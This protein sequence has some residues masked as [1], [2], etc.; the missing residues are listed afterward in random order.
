MRGKSLIILAIVAVVLIAAALWSREKP[1]TATSEEELL[2][3]DLMANINAVKTINFKSAG[4]TF[5][6]QKSEDG[7]ELDQKDGYAAD[8]EKVRAMLLGMARTKRLEA[9]TKNPDLYGKLQLEDVDNEGAQ[10]VLISLVDDKNKLLADVVFGK[11][12]SAKAG[13]A[14]REYYVRVGDDPQSWLVQSDFE[15]VKD[16]SQWLLQEVLAIDES[17]IRSAEVNHED[18][19]TIEVQRDSSGETN[20][21]LVDI[22]EGRKVKYEFS[23]NDVANSFANLKLQD[24]SKVDE[25]D[26]SDAKRAVVQSFDGLM[27]TLET[28]QKD[29]VTYARLNAEFSSESVEKNDS[30]ENAK[31]ETESADQSTNTINTI[32]EVKQEVE[33]L[34]ARWSGWAYQLPDFELNNIFKPMDELLEEI[35]SSEDEEEQASENN[36][37]AQN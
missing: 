16:A 25:I 36:P 30:A 8:T 20:F 9:K 15:L 3:P 6:V 29:D 13:P 4:N 11:S 10:S 27:V 1:Q 35:E 32:D 23:V 18:G 21:T 2:L 26:F 14:Q 7:W 24:V 33:R 17:R 22:P 34:N 28:A 5:S 19:T 12:Q 37:E 31:A